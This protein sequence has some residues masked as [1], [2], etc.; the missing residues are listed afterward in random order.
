VTQL[1]H[2]LSQMMFEQSPG[3][4]ILGSRP[5]CIEPT[6]ALLR[7]LTQPLDGSENCSVL[8]LELFKELFEVIG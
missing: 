4:A 3:N 2:V 7:W 8:A 5:K 6:V 1:R